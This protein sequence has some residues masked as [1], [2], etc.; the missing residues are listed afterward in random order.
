MSSAF[1]KAKRTTGEGNTLINPEKRDNHA[2]KLA[3]CEKSSFGKKPKGH[4]IERT[5]DL[6]KIY[7]LRLIKRKLMRIRKSSI[8]LQL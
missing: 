2:E 3:S 4:G 6:E 7:L 5:K 1:G 8:F